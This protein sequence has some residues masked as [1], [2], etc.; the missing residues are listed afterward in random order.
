MDGGVRAPEL[1]RVAADG[2]VFPVDTKTRARSIVHAGLRASGFRRSD[3]ALRTGVDSGLADFG[4]D[5][6]PNAGGFRIR[7]P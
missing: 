6:L 3:L 1:V 2:P 4:A 5:G 7:F